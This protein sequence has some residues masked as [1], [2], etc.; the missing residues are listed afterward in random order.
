M[1]RL[2]RVSCSQHNDQQTFT[3]LMSGALRFPKW[4]IPVSTGIQTRDTS[5]LK[6]SALTLIISTKRI[7][8]C[9]FSAKL[10]RWLSFTISLLILYSSLD[11]FTFMLVSV[12][13]Q[14]LFFFLLLNW[15]GMNLIGSSV[16]WSLCWRL[17]V[18]VYTCIIEHSPN[19]YLCCFVSLMTWLMTMS[20]SS[21][22]FMDHTLS[23]NSMFLFCLCLINYK[24]ARCLCNI[25]GWRFVSNVVLAATYFVFFAFLN[26]PF[27]VHVV[28][29]ICRIWPSQR[30]YKTHKLF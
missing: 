14:D 9:Q 7:Q 23:A 13:I 19:E 30:R 28:T 25:S 3:H 11:L 8:Q 26:L 18:A 10:L 17:S 20:S 2:T 27:S 22:S 1:P 4:K 16:L 15:M 21:V 29:L 24:L 12:C 6:P 5:V